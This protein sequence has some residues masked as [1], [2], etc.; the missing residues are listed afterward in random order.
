V[1]FDESMHTRLT[2]H[3]TIE[4]GLRNAIGSTQLY[5]EF[6]PII[7]LATGR[8]VSAEALLRWQHPTLGVISPAEFI[9]IAEESGLI[10]PVGRWVQQQACQALAQWRALDPARSPAS[11]S[12]N[13]SRAEL[14]LGNKLFVQLSQALE[15]AGLPP[16][17][18]TLEVTEREVMRD[19]EAS[20][21]L[22]NE[23]RRMGIKLSMDDFGTG[24][25]SLA[26]LRNYPF[27]TIKIHRSFVC[28]L[29]GS[30]EALAVLH[31][32]IHLIENLGMTS[33]AEGVETG[34]QAAVLQSLGC[35]RAQ[36]YLFGRP[37]PAHTMP[38]S[39]AEA[40]SRLM[41]T[42]AAQLAQTGS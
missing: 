5:I 22:M 11:I 28:D 18:L 19:P 23:L 24:T 12:V 15:Q 34:A 41:A 33:L 3:V 40:G 30:R 32:T 36:G 14:A 20:L 38:A 16:H 35:R 37:V 1:V 31:A 27:D 26:L 4:T 17:C 9:P 29:P 6:Q 13:V 25:S 39:I 21:K 8:V 10:V 7:E 42:A 2:R